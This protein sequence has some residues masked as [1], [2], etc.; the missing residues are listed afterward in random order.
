M[1]NDDSQR[2]MTHSPSPAASPH[3]YNPLTIHLRCYT[4]GTR[5]EL[6]PSALENCRF[7]RTIESRE[8]KAGLAVLTPAPPSAD[9]ANNSG[10]LSEGPSSEKVSSPASTTPIPTSPQAGASGSYCLYV[11]EHI[12]T[13][14]LYDILRGRLV[15]NDSAGPETR[16][17]M[18]VMRPITFEKDLAEDEEP[19]ECPCFY[20]PHYDVES[21]IKAVYNEDRMYEHLSQFQGK[22]I[23]QYYGLYTCQDESRDQPKL[24]VM[25]LED[26]GPQENP[27]NMMDDEYSVDECK[28][29]LEIYYKLHHE[30]N[31]AHYIPKFWHVLRRQSVPKE[32]EDHLVMIDFANAISLETKS[33][34]E[35]E[36]LIKHDNETWEV[37]NRIDTDP[38]GNLYT[39]PGWR[40]YDD[41]DYKFILG[42]E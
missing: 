18:K 8:D 36:I 10:L 38:E 2:V 3:E 35:R 42:I 22:I 16:V 34:K 15:V 20:N 9:V 23:P 6:D 12:Y 39:Y 4:G 24:M 17:V 33:I 37:S 5:S 41:E 7:Q 29:P 1:P 14:Q 30:K 11:D 26:L 40:N 28:R 31:I 27:F 13:G 19:L 25:L 32:H 21:A